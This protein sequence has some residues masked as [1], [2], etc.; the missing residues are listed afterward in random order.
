[1]FSKFKYLGLCLVVTQVA[2]ASLN[3]QADSQSFFPG[4]ERDVRNIFGKQ[5]KIEKAYYKEEPSD[6]LPNAEKADS[7]PKQPETPQEKIIAEYGDPK[8]PHEVKAIKDAPKPFQ[9]MI[10]A[11][12]VG[13]KKLAF[14][15][16]V[17]YQNYIEALEKIN[18][19]A[20]S[21]HGLAMYK[22]GAIP[23][24]GW[25]KSEINNN[26]DLMQFIDEQPKVE[27]QVGRLA[28]DAQELLKKAKRKD[29]DLFSGSP[30]EKRDIAQAERAQARSELTGKVPYL[31]TGQVDVYFFF[32]TTDQKSID[33]A[34][35]LQT[36]F[37]KLDDSDELNILGFSL[38][39]VSDGALANFQKR[40]GAKF[41]TLASKE[42]AQK[43]NITSAPTIMVVDSSSGKF[44][45]INDVVSANYLDEMFKIVRGK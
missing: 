22:T 16:A 44:Y 35:A 27:N 7:T 18:K 33:L 2:I 8:L 43:L 23:A 15:Y 9:A 21:I 39:D 25:V 17:Q 11:L 1:M 6:L 42:L 4:Q 41:T 40:T 28:V 30:E 31:P 14:E 29:N 12:K 37:A 20:A 34:T 38:D 10:E 32:K 5:L 13:D 26:P 3:C 19:D 36:V 45:Q 24:D